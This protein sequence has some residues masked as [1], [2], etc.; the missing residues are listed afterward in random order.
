MTHQYN[1]RT[2]KGDFQDA[3]ASMEQNITN[4]INSIKIDINSIKSDIS[5]VKTDLKGEINNLKD[6]ILK[7][8]TMKMQLSGNIPLPII[9]NNMVEEIILLSVVFQIV[10]I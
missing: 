9:L 10:L 3:L 4:Y 1:T 6:V 2:N 5:S 7:D 8:C